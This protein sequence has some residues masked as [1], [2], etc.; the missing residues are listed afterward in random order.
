MRHQELRVLPGQTVDLAA[1]PARSDTAWEGSKQ[2]GKYRVKEIAK[3]LS[4]LQKLYY[5]D[6]SNRLLVV[7]QAMD[8]GGKDSTIRDVF[9]RMN[10]QGVR[11]TSF[12]QPTH[13]ELAHDYLW[14][15]HPHVPGD[16]EIAIFNRSHYEDVLVVR[17]DE[18]AP[19]EVWEKRFGHIVEFERLLADEGTRIVKFFIHI[20]K[21]EQKERLEAR[22][23]DPDKHWKFSLGDLETR[24]KWDRFQTAYAD[25]LSRTSTDFA[26]WYVIPGDRK[27][28]RKLVIGEIMVDIMR[29]LDL[30]YPENEDDLSGVVVE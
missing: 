14:R 23:E 20:S 24:E 3:E 26:P 30:S 5:A 19:E 13:R 4:D 16:G 8:T 25:A 22:L 15:V 28:Y 17:V 12:K 18:I 11:V 29:S 7:L 2:A 10:P 6:G 27:W 1:F 9:G 21:E